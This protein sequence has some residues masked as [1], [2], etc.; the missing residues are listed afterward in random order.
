MITTWWWTFSL[1]TLNLGNFL[2]AEELLIFQE[3]LLHGANL[4]N[5]IYEG[6]PVS[7]HSSLLIQ[8]HLFLAQFSNV[9]LNIIFPLAH[10]S[11]MWPLT[12][13][14]PHKISLTCTNKIYTPSSIPGQFTWDLWWPKWHR[15]RISPSTSVFPCQY[16]ST[17][18]P[19]SFLSPVTSTI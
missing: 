17:K 14:L 1:Y 3:G 13:H 15:D 7:S 4:H 9:H 10:A 19:Y 12:Q 5:L 2:V 6:L 11:S 16:H 8:I 18:A